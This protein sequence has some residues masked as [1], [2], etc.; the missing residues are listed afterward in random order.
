MQSTSEEISMNNE[1]NIV[2]LLMIDHRF[3]KEC[4]ST[5]V[6]KKT[7]KSTKLASVNKF[8]EVL[9]KHSEAEGKTVY[10]SLADMEILRTFILEGEVEHEI[11]KNNI[12]ALLPKVSILRFLDDQTELEVKVLAKFVEYRLKQEEKDI[13]P[14]IRKYLDSSILNEIGFQF[15][16]MRKFSAKEL[17][18]NPVLQRE[19]YQIH[20][21][22]MNNQKYNVYTV[23]ADF[24]RKVNRYINSLVTDSQYI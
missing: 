2:D 3:L 15:M 11:I 13:F 6:D 9:K 1:F 21:N 19:I 18:N 4:I 16:I 22:K 5:I 7:D 20:Y 24:I 17:K 23:S 8:L 10:D 12:N 14:K